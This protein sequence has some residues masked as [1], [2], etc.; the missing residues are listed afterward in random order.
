LDWRGSAMQGIRDDRHGQAV[1][2]T[3]LKRMRIFMM[4]SSA[5]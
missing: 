2:T 5:M 1:A 3:T 4:L